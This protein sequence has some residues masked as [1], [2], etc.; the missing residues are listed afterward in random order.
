LLALIITG[1][2]GVLVKVGRGVKVGEEVLEYVGRG[3]KVGS[4]TGAEVLGGIAADGASTLAIGGAD[5]DGAPASGSVSLEQAMSRKAT[6]K[7]GRFIIRINL[8]S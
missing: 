7:T 8:Y 5:W 1:G 4:M 6:N 2:F 3:V